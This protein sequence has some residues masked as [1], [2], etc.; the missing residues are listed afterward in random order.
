MIKDVTDLNVYNEANRLLLKLY[1]LF[2]EVPKSELDLE[3][4]IKRAAKSISANIAEGFGKRHFGK[5]FRRY[6][7]NALGSSDEVISHLRT[8]TLIKPN[9]SVKINS[10]LDEYK[11][12]SKRIN[13]LHKYWRF[14]TDPQT[15]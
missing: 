12:L 15:H 13:S 9:L 5:E 3:W 11:I 7:L 4:Q 10:L 8:L 2:K 1:Q 6:L 14:D